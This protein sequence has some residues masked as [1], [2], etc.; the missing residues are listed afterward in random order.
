MFV[1]VL[2][3]EV[4]LTVFE[5]SESRKGS[6]F[7]HAYFRTADLHGRSFI[8]FASTGAASGHTLGCAAMSLRWRGQGCRS[9]T[10][11][12]KD[13]LCSVQIIPPPKKLNQRNS[14]KT[15]PPAG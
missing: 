1:L 12:S 2:E 3:H 8:P 10:H 7:I 9:I 4:L 6:S 14:V 5:Q 13:V 15:P 11:R